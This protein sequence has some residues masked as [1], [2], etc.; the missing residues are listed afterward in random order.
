S[1]FCTPD[2]LVLSAIAGP[3][4]ADVFLREA[5]WANETLE[6]AMLQKQDNDAKL[7]AFFRKA[8]AE[9]LQKEHHVNLPGQLPATPAATAKTLGSL[10]ER[11]RHL[12]LGEQGQVH[13]LLAV[14]PLPR[15]DEIYQVVFENI[16]NQQ[17]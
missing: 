14:T 8:H 1:Y 7:R 16:L 2:G 15:I 17:I 6:L 12:G 13:L 11:N 9:R 4:N 10:L 3:V 5:R